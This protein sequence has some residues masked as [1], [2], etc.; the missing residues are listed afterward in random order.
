MLLT[1]PIDKTVQR[2]PKRPNI[3]SL[4]GKFGRAGQSLYFTKPIQKALIGMASKIAKIG[5]NRMLKSV[6]S[7]RRLMF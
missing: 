3:T 2:K 5:D 1:N 7:A 6:A 4:E